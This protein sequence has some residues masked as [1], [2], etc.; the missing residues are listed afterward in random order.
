MEPTHEFGKEAMEKRMATIKKNKRNMRTALIIIPLLV[1]AILIISFRTQIKD[2]LSTTEKSKAIQEKNTDSKN[3]KSENSISILQRWDLPEKLLEISG[4]SWIDNERFACVQDETGIVFIY[5]AAKSSIEKEIA[6][7][8]AGDYEGLAVVGE[9]VWVIRSDGKLYE[10]NSVKTNKAVVKEHDTP[11]TAKHNAE[12]LCYDSKNNRLLIALKDGEPGSTDYK[13][14][15]SFELATKKMVDQPVIKIDLKNE[16]FSGMG[17]S[18]KKAKPGDV[19]MPSGIAVHPTTGD[20]YITEGRKPKLL[21]TDAA[22][23]IKRLIELD[24]TDFLQPE[25]ITFSSNGELFISNEGLKQP[26]NILKLHLS[27]K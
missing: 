12:G 16:M 18:K 26:G 10:I 20:I 22:G 11:L 9:T 15:Y 5:N 27:T 2:V 23:T 7:A 17:S 8:G 4:L 14:I 25:G 1:I 13:G 6:F 24:K 3:P 19:I 21:I